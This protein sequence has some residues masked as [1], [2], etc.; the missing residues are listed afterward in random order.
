MPAEPFREEAR[1][2]NCDD[3]V[4][5][6]GAR[7]DRYEREHIGGAVD[8]RCPAALEERP[9]SPEHDR[10]GEYELDPVDGSYRE[11]MLEGLPRNHFRHRKEEYRQRQNQAY[12]KTPRHIYQLRVL[13]I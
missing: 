7:A 2:K 11:R 1:D 10:S 8:D 4:E 9:P 12:P 5:I 13:F 3:A 6:G